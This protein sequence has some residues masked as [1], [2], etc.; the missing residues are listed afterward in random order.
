MFLP[1]TTP[2]L[3]LS[4]NP[5]KN[6]PRGRT[7]SL[8]L[9]TS[10]VRLAGGLLPL[11]LLLPNHPAAPGGRASARDTGTALLGRGRSWSWDLEPLPRGNR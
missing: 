7:G 11:L 9:G 2:S 4:C 3:R 8:Q 5:T 6:K 10:S 1:V